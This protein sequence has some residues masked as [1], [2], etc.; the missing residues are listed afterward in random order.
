MLADAVKTVD[1]VG[2]VTQQSFHSEIAQP[3]F[4]FASIFSDVLE[5]IPKPSGNMV[6][7]AEKDLGLLNTE[8]EELKEIQ[9]S[10][11]T[12]EASIN[13]R[14]NTLEARSTRSTTLSQRLLVL[15]CRVVV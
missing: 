4:L 2:E 14:I 3:S 12:L 8:G 11:N 13:T 9:A 1:S 7:A 6:R 15:R 10:I 5:K